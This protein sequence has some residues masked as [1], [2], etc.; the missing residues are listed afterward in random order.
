MKKT[1]NLK[2]WA[3]SARSQRETTRPIA[4][5]SFAYLG[6]LVNLDTSF[7]AQVDT[8]AVQDDA[9]LVK[10]TVVQEDSSSDTINTVAALAEKAA[11]YDEGDN[12]YHNSK[13]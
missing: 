3:V 8:T 5:W 12:F 7:E 13:A 4:N 9:Q 2:S 6:T 1:S 11:Q 10:T